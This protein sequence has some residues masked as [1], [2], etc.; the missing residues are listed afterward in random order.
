[1]AIQNCPGTGKKAWSHSHGMTSKYVVDCPDCKLVISISNKDAEKIMVP[2][3]PHGK[4][5]G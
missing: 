1:M 5:G 4:V 3:P 2:V